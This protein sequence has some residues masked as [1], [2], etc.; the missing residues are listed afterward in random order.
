MDGREMTSP[1]AVGVESR[2]D[3]LARLQRTYD[4]SIRTFRLGGLDLEIAALRDP[5]RLLDAATLEQAHA[6]MTWQPYWGKVWAAS[7]GLGQDLASRNWNGCIVADL[8][9]GLGVPG[10]VAAAQ[11]ANV[12]FI[13]NAPPALEFVRWNSWPWRQRVEIARFDWRENQ[14]LGQR[15]D[16]ILGSDI[17][18]AREDIPCLDR[19]WRRHLR[20][21]GTVLLSE[22]CRLLTGDLL[23]L[24]TAA[25]WRA[26]QR[27][28]Q[29]D[30]SGERVNIIALTPIAQAE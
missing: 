26:A 30:S 29:V 11:G 8:G 23:P 20:E 14:E 15:F 21:S 12:W 25:G 18:Y 6:E 24:V 4:L 1:W 13:D 27:T 7:L 2:A 17:L 9:C 5:D 22:P 28:V 10:A 16:L 3:L 19:F